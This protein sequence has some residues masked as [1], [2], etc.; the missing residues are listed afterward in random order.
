MSTLFLSKSFLLLGL[1][2]YQ[3]FFTNCQ[4]TIH[5]FL[6]DIYI[7]I[8]IFFYHCL[9]LHFSIK[10]TININ[11][12]QFFYYPSR[13][14]MLLFINFNSSSIGTIFLK[15]KDPQLC[16]RKTKHEEKELL[17]SLVWF[18]G[19]STLVGYLILNSVDIYVWF[20]GK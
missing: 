4:I 2:S 7:Y 19:I 18:Y 12:T 6:P 11:V 3:F 1:P 10:D 16:L 20:V 14:S 8:Y 15:F 9:M 13:R 17:F 5:Y